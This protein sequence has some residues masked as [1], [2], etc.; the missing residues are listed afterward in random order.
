MQGLRPLSDLQE[1]EVQEAEVEAEDDLQEAEAPDQRRRHRQ[2]G[3]RPAVAG[4]LASG[5]GVVPAVFAD[6]DADLAARDDGDVAVVLAAQADAVRKRSLAA[7]GEVGK[8]SASP[9]PI[10]KEKAD[11]TDP[12]A[13]PTDRGA[14]DPDEDGRQGDLS[15]TSAND[16][17]VVY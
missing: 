7:Q 14:A 12:E 17:A 4:G 8:K 1:A 6:A 16:F 15:L 9:V 13:D 5:A 2:D 11:L 10:D 3:R